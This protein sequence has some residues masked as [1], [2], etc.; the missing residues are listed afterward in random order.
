MPWQWNE[1]RQ[2]YSSDSEKSI[3]NLIN[4]AKYEFTLSGKI[5]D[6]VGNYISVEFEDGTLEYGEEVVAKRDVDPTKQ[7]ESQ[8]HKKPIEFTTQPGDPAPVNPS[9]PVVKIEIPDESNNP[10]IP[11]EYDVFYF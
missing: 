3:D 2:Y 8:V 1:L 9:P 6:V 7:V 5:E 11:G 10:R 4:E